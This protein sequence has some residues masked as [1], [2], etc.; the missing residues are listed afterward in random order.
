MIFIKDD[1]LK[2]ELS[3]VETFESNNLNSIPISPSLSYLNFLILK[4]TL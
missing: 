1:Y 2:T 4:I 3:S